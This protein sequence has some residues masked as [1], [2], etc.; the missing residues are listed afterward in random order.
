MSNEAEVAAALADLIAARNRG[1]QPL[2]FAP[3]AASEQN[4]RSA[5][6]LRASLPGL[7]GGWPRVRDTVTRAAE[8]VGL[9]SK[10]I[11]TFENPA[12]TTISAAQA[13]V[14]RI[15]VERWCRLTVADRL[16]MRADLV[17]AGEGILC[18]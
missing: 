1:A 16:G 15:A 12:A 5:G 7:E 3:E 13:E 8:L 11:A 18:N 10:T 17:G 4:G 2:A 14:A 6:Q 9:L